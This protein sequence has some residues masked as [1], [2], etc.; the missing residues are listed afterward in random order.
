[1]TTLGQIGEMHIT[2]WAE[3]IWEVVDLILGQFSGSRSVSTACARAVGLSKK[4]RLGVIA[5]IG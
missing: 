3:S 4:Q 1:M 5:E 2:T